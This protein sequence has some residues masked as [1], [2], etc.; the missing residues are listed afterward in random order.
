MST[1]FV[2]QY[3]PGRAVP[4]KPST[5]ILVLHGTGGDEHDLL[6]VGRALVPGAGLLSPRGRVVEAGANR[7]FSR[8]SAGVF[9]QDEIRTRAAELAAWIGD[10]VRQYDL[11]PARLYALG[12]SNGANMAAATILLHPGSIAGGVLLRPMPVIRPEPLPELNGAPVLIVAGQR[13]DTTSPEDATRLAR[14]LTDAGAAV[15]LAMQN[16]GHDLTPQDFA[17]GKQWFAGLV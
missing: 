11:D 14:L 15:D 4:G 5:T 12:Y 9:D 6:P 1:E 3:V 7:F 13:D 10:A 2:H 17:I 16:A 8:V